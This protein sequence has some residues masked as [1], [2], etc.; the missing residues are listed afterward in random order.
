MIR[1]VAKRCC[2][3]LLSLALLPATTFAQPGPG[4]DPGPRSAPAPGAR[5][6]ERLRREI[7]ERRLGVGLQVGERFTFRTVSM[8]INGVSAEPTA[9]WDSATSGA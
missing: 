3:A 1:H 7:R 6:P 4:P 2:T 8:I 5:R 9:S